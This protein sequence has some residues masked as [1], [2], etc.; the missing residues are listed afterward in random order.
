MFIWEPPGD[1]HGRE[2]FIGKRSIFFRYGRSGVKTK[3]PLSHKCWSV[4]HAS[5]DIVRAAPVAELSSCNAS[6][7]ADD[8][9]ACKLP[10]ECACDRFH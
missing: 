3:H 1:T 7:D 5:N 10:T 4:R 2:Q 9:F 6:R 8:E